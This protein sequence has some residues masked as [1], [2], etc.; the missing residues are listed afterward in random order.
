MSECHGQ[1][2]IRDYIYLLLFVKN[3]AK[4]QLRHRFP[5]Q[6]KVAMMPLNQKSKPPHRA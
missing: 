6:Q 2:D 3:T 5:Q 1:Y 4:S